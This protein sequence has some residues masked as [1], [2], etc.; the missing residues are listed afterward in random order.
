MLPGWS[1]STFVVEPEAL[2]AWIDEA[3]ACG[4]TTIQFAG[5]L[6]TIAPRHLDVLSPQADIG[7]AATVARFRDGLWTAEDAVGRGF[8]EAV[9]A[10]HPIPGVRAIVLGAGRVARA[11][12]TAMAL[13]GAAHLLILNRTPNRARFLADVI[14]DRAGVPADPLTWPPGFL[15][16]PEPRIL[17]QATSI[18]HDPEADTP[19]DLDLGSLH[20]GLLVCDTAFTA[21]P[22]RLL[23][24]ATARGCATL[25]GIAWLAAQIAVETEFATGQAPSLLALREAVR[26]FE[27]LP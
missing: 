8:L 9:Q 11:V 12:A 24:E 16:P 21:R 10:V 6:E 13:A 26:R 4:W 7:D 25:G 14:R 23:R 3:A 2:G 15:I 22:T 27:P 19:P 18:G 17:I 5:G 1:Q 20:P